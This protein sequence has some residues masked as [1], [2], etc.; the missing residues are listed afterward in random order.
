MTAP[1]FRFNYLT[2]LLF[3]P[4]A[5]QAQTTPAGSTGNIAKKDKEDIEV[6]EIKGI[7]GS[8]LNSMNIKRGSGNIVDAITAEDIGKFPDQN[9]AES[10]QRITGVSI[11][12]EGGEGQLVTVRGLG[13]EFNSV[14]MNGRTLASISGGRA[15]S[16]DTLASEL[17]SGADVNKTQYASLQ[18]GSIGALVNI[19]TLKPF[20]IN[21]FKAT[22]SVKAMYDDMTGSTT[23]QLSGLVSDTL[24]DGTLGLLFSYSHSKRE[25]RYDQAQ[26]FGYIVRD[27]NLDNGTQPKGV[28]LPRNYDQIVHNETR[29]RDGGTLVAQYQASDDLV[30]T[31]DL[32]YTSYDV[33]Y[34][35]DILAHWFVNSQV[36]AAELDENRTVVK[37]THGRGSNTDYLNRLSQRPTET[38][39]AG[40]NADWKLNDQ[41]TL[42]ADLFRSLANS[43]GGGRTTD[44]VASYA[45][46]YTFDNSSGAMLP[47]IEFKQNQSTSGIKAGWASRFGSDLSDA[48]S[49]AKLQGSWQLEDGVL[50]KVDFGAQWSERK[51]KS[52]YAETPFD[53][54]VLYGDNPTPVILPESLFGKFGG[55]F[56]T[57]AS[58]NPPQQW[59]TFSSEDLFRF[60][61]S[62][63]AIKQLADP[64]A[65]RALL[66]QYPGYQALPSP[67]TYQIKEATASF[68]TDL[69]FEGELA[70]RVWT[71]HTGL[72]YADTR[73]ESVGQQIWL[74]DLI[75]SQSE[76]G[77][78]NAKQSEDYL[79]IAVE[80]D[81]GQWLP[82]MNSSL[83][84]VDDVIARFAW[85]RSMT[86]PELGYMSPITGYGGGKTDALTGSGGNPKLKPFVSDN[87]DLTLEWYYGEGS[88]LALAKFRKDVKNYVDY[89][90]FNETVTVPSGTYQYQVSR[91]IN[92]NNARIDGHELAVQHLFS[93]LPAPFDGLGIIANL[94]KVDSSSSANTPDNPL[95]LVGLGDS[96]NLILFYEKNGLELRIA[97]NNRKEFMQS[98]ENGYGGKPIYVDDYAQW[99]VSGSYDLTTQLSVFFEGLN[100]TNELTR[101]RGL[102]SNHLL[103]VIETGPRYAV[104]I[105]G[106][107]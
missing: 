17:I 93:N 53:L 107:F 105:R 62:D 65:G 102:Y 28:Y 42:K 30:L 12:R 15:F 55:G 58:G 76:P 67:T 36:M 68:Y 57:G 54:S 48:I 7:K 2:A 16:F 63:A 27:L 22:G 24:L 78:V 85:S 69:F 89:G 10:L 61:Q 8:L 82:S 49:E 26:T 91:P 34:R 50:Q 5:L 77:T 97:Y 66:T 13:P 43:D 46:T 94:T 47:S 21:G 90:I 14:L 29:R 38:K 84:L 71:L 83:E 106:S 101:K 64:V 19:R 73:N 75:P 18:E 4:L 40:L 79:P 104:G 52:A 81:Y 86:R 70:E 72:R 32:L 88:Y 51:L 9:V 33:D 6:I 11:D 99:D 74:L 59:L 95:P 100:V 56:L 98:R 45:N 96:E 25:S 35:Q 41:L 44:T 3:M 37:L 92:L 31:A 39:A 23:P 103:N 60:L 80:H 87:L 1:K 20:D